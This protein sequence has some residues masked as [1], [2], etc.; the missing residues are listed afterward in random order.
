MDNPAELDDVVGNI[1]RPLSDDELRVIPQWLGT[2]WR[3]L[4]RAVPGIAVR[5]ALP[6][7][8]AGHLS[9]DDVKDVVIAM[10]ERKVRN[11][12]GLRTWNGDDYGQ[13]IDSELSAGKIYVTA[14][15]VALLSPNIGYPASGIF[16]IPLG[17]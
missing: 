7:S 10:V 9:V 12:A 1:D 17:R 15:E 4:N 8:A 3:R 6:E 5:T 16:S 14:D 13:T 11:S 2:A